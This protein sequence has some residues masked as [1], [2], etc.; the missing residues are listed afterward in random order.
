MRKLS[1][2]ILAIVAVAGLL[3]ASV[4]LAGSAVHRASGGGTVDWPGGRVTYG[5]TA[6]I[7][8]TGEVKGEAEFHFRD[9]GL[10][11]HVDINCLAVSGNVAWLGGT[12]T[13]SDDPSV[14]GMEVTWQVKDNGQGKAAPPDR[15][16]IVFI[17]VASGDCNDMKW[18]GELIPWTNG[19]VQIN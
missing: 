1:V 8:A 19:N 6:R 2:V 5:F 16:G 12:I 18:R 9:T 14:V 15:T 17:G 11:S 4:A 10:R 7:D 13:R 3:G